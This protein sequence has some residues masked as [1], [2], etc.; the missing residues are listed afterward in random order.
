MTEIILVRYKLP[1]VEN[2]CLKSVLDY[3]SNYH[4]TVYD[5]APQNINL[6]KLW[7]QLI[8]RSDAD[9]ICLLNTDT[10]VEPDWLTKLE[11][12]LS[13]PS[14][15]K[16][17][18]VG[19]V[20]NQ[21]HNCQK[22]ERSGK[23]AYEMPPH[24][25]LGGF[26]LLFLKSVWEEVGGIPEDFGFYGQETAFLKKVQHKGYKQLVRP[27]VFVFHYGAASAKEAE[28]RGEMVVEKERVNARNL[29]QKFSELWR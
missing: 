28:K 27:D 17:A 26:C 3:T 14:W 23:P 7:N 20:T 1:K 8:K 11:E 29:Y 18:A 22:Q 25:M 13:A 10:I 15:S 16:V 6:G 12:T 24:E 19:P 5:N 21:T 4:L 9:T 2:D